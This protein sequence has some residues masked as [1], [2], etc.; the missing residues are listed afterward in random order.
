MFLINSVCDIVMV[1]VFTMVQARTVTGHLLIGITY[2]NPIQDMQIYQ[3]EAS[4]D[5]SL[6][7]PAMCLNSLENS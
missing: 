2:L 3:L 7:S 6:R 1:H 4:S 5:L